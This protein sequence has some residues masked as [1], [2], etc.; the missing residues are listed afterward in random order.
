MF[1][2][3][4]DVRYTKQADKEKIFTSVRQLYFFDRQVFTGDAVFRQAVEVDRASPSI[5]PLKIA[6]TLID[7]MARA[8][9]LHDLNEDNMGRVLIKTAEQIGS[10][11][12]LVDFVV[13]ATTV[14]DY[15]I[16]DERSVTEG[17]I[18]GNGTLGYSGMSFL[19]RTLLMR[20]RVEKIALGNAAVE[21]LL[22]GRAKLSAPGR[23]K[24]GLEVAIERSFADIRTWIT[25][26][27]AAG[28]PTKADIIGIDWEVALA[29]LDN[30]C[31]AAKKNFAD[32]RSGLRAR[33]GEAAQT[34]KEVGA[35]ARGA[36]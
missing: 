30:Y 25:T 4:Q 24:M 3:T 29:D 7:I 10:K 2:A 26:P 9:R 5:T 36:P 12:K 32:L 21:V 28:G 8:F 35:V 14:A 19:S 20:E 11:W 33:Q 13:G 23:R 16:G 1:I 6:V 17:F 22:T 31:Q 34:E 27:I 15:V 18:K